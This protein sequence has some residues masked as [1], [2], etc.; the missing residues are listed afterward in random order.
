MDP[1][2][3]PHYVP[4]V[5]KAVLAWNAAFEEAGFRNAVEVRDAPSAKEDPEWVVEDARYNVVRWLP[6]DKQNAIGRKRQELGVC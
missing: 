6:S 5:K 1:A 4:Y 3:P 2:I